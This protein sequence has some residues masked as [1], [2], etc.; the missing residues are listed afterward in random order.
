M[1]PAHWIMYRRKRPLLDVSSVPSMFE[2]SLESGIPISKLVNCS[3]IG[4]GPYVIGCGWGRFLVGFQHSPVQY[5]ATHPSSMVLVIVSYTWGGMSNLVALYN[6]MVNR[7]NAKDLFYLEL[8]STIALISL[9]ITQASST[10]LPVTTGES[11]WL[12]ILIQ[13]ITIPFQTNLLRTNF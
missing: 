10:Y 9:A 7:G 11:Y 4:L 13:I 1:Q 2:R 5:L 6:S 8:D 12:T 3:M